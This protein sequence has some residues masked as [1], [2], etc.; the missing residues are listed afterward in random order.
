MYNGNNQSDHNPIFVEF[1]LDNKYEYMK[2][3]NNKYVSYKQK[4]TNENFVVQHCFK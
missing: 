4:D 2:C 1:K 3:E